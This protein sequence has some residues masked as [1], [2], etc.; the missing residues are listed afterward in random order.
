MRQTYYISDGDSGLFR[1]VSCFSLCKSSSDRFRR[2]P[3]LST[4]TYIL[5]T[6]QGDAR[7]WCGPKG[8]SG[9]ELEQ[10]VMT[11]NWEKKVFSGIHG[12]DGLVHSTSLPAD[13]WTGVQRS[14]WAQLQNTSWLSVSGSSGRSPQLSDSRARCFWNLVW[15]CSALLLVFFFFQVFFMFKPANFLFILKKTCTCYVCVCSMSPLRKE[16]EPHSSCKCF[17]CE[18]KY[19]NI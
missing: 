12:F 13:I 7:T 1:A 3:H 6:W 19:P 14:L 10:G 8:C 16:M 4:P 11:R 18:A 2:H 15:F 5:P 9:Q 17:Y